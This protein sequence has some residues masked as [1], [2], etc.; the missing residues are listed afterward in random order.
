MV[1]QTVDRLSPMLIQSE[2]LLPEHIVL[3]Q[4]I[5]RWSGKSYW[6][7]HP[8]FSELFICRPF[9][10]YIGELVS[11]NFCQWIHEQ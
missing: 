11:D 1:D 6:E 2:Y 3:I 8:T 5:V 10:E 7:V 9:N 4:Q